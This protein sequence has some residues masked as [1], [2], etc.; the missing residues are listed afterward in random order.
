MIGDEKKKKELAM[1]MAERMKKADAR[2][3]CVI[4]VESDYVAQSSPDDK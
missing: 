3:E 2:Y 1:H 4:T